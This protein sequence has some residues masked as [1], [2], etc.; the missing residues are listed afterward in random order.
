[1]SGGGEGEGGG[2]KKESLPIFFP[3]TSPNVGIRLQN[4]LTFTFNLFAI[5]L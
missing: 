3:V 2:S 1:M 5:L 4:F